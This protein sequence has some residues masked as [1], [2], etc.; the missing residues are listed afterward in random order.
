MN[1]I[2][3]FEEFFNNGWNR[4]LRFLGRGGSVKHAPNFKTTNSNHAKSKKNFIKDN[5]NSEIAKY[6][7]FYGSHAYFED[8]SD[9]QVVNEDVRLVNHF[10]LDFD[11]DF[12]DGSEFKKITKGDGEDNLGIEELK[13]LTISEYCAGMD[14][15]HEQIQDMIIYENI[16]KDSWNESKKVYD[17]FKSEGLKTYTCLSM[18]KGVH[19]RCFFNSVHV[20]N[21]NRI[22]HTLHSN[23]VKQ[24][25]LKTLDERVTGEESNP[26]KSVERL[27]YTFNAKSGLR[28][29]PF[30]FETDSLVDVIERSIKLSHKKN[31]V[32]VDSFNLSDYVN[33]D[34]H[35]KILKS[36]K[37][38]GEL[39]AEQH[40]KE[41]LLQKIR[42]QQDTIKNGTIKGNYIGGKGLFKDLRIL[43][44]FVC[45]ED[46][47][48]KEHK[49]YDKYKCVFHSDASPSAF[50]GVKYYTCLSSNCKINKLNYFDFIREWFGL[51]S[52]REVK[53]KMVEL[54][55]VY[56]E[57]IHGGI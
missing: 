8:V 10:F 17:Y 31:L 5:I 14:S 33:P 9:Y 35:N 51:D 43:V 48:V 52:D 7:N 2:N 23:L 47:L 22:I 11:K 29:T 42:S 6:T 55:T 54:Q 39:I 18:S 15:I 56:D 24:F 53:E 21:Y 41:Q 46:N 57:K 1:I 38:V 36:D 25:N 28:V 34:F 49:D 12:P 40:K 19:L 26:L 4:D 20:K 13:K 50:V 27:P 30:S 37:K 16:L 32:Q 45:G 44:R 3:Y